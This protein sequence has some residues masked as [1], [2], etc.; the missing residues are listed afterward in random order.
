MSDASSLTFLRRHAGQVPAPVALPAAGSG[1]LLGEEGSS[2]PIWWYAL[3]AGGGLL[4]LGGL[5]SLRRT[6]NRR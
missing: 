3:A 5:V 4:V 6:D 1:G 2:L